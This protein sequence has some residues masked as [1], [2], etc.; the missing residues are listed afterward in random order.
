MLLR[1]QGQPPSVLCTWLL[2]VSA[3][4]DAVLRAEAGPDTEQRVQEDR[5]QLKKEWEAAVN[6]QAESLGEDGIKK[7]RPPC[8]Y[9]RTWRACVQQAG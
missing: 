8:R 7:V 5:Q 9:S 6:G 3:T 1:V 4:S 2:A